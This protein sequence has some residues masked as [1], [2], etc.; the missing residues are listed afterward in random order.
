MAKN[1]TTR[2]KKLEGLREVLWPGSEGRVWS[3][4]KETGY[5]CVPRVLPLLQLLMKD[6]TVMGGAQ[7]GDCGPVYLEL[8][9]HSRGQGIVE[10]ISEGEH[11]YLAG[12][13]GSRALRTWRERI[14]SLEKAGFLEIRPRPN[15]AIGF[16]LLV[17]PHLAVTS[18]KEKGKLP[19]GWWETYQRLQREHGASTPKPQ[20]V[21]KALEL[22]GGRQSAQRVRR[23]K[24]SSSELKSA[25]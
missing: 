14:A 18:L 2:D 21:A 24:A 19:E 11:A 16:I 8:M 25:T 22:V 15:Q 1:P 20:R 10:I 7:A 17:H 13:S 9:T 12:Y 5:C 6:K 23:K 4:A 3:A